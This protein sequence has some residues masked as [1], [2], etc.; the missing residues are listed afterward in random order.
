MS[1]Q[2]SPFPTYCGKFFRLSHYLYI[3][4]S[5]I[6]HLANSDITLKCSI[7]AKTQTRF[8][9]LFTSRSSSAREESHRTSPLG[10]SLLSIYNK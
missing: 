6:N 1:F 8:M 7:K 10:I 4:Q 2:M 3:R 5:V 9:V